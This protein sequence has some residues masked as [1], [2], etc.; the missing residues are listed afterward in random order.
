MTGFVENTRVVKDINL[1]EGGLYD[2]LY[3]DLVDGFPNSK[4]IFSLASTA[5]SVS[6]EGVSRRVTGLQKLVQQFL[7][8][9][10]T[11]RGTDVVRPSV[12]TSMPDILRYSNIGNRAELENMIRS[13]IA[14]ASTQ[15]ADITSTLSS[16]YEVLQE[17]SLIDLEIGQVSISLGISILS[18]AGDEASLIAPFPRFDLPIN[19]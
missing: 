6:A 2:I 4:L 5:E 9:L 7:R 3:L 17:A 1:A 13:E 18:A 10:F 11:S 19:V 16:E 8:V 14:S 15:V 12:G